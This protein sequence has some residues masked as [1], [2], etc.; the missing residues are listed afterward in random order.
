MYYPQ[1]GGFLPNF[2]ALNGNKWLDRAALRQQRTPDE[3]LSILR[4]L[5]SRSTLHIRPG[6]LDGI[7]A[8]VEGRMPDEG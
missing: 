1:F 7:I 8:E 5:P 2:E 3:V 6:L 4:D